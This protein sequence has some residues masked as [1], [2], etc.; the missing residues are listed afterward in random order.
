LHGTVLEDEKNCP[1]GSIGILRILGLRELFYRIDSGKLDGSI[2]LGP[3]GTGSGWGER[4]KEGRGGL[5][6]QL[7]VTSITN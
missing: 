5:L 2:G 1:A 7:I 3:V 4:E 6:G